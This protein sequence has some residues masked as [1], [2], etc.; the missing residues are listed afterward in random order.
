MI[1]NTAI[2]AVDLT[3]DELAF[4][5]TLYGLEEIGG[6]RVPAD[7]DTSRAAQAGAALMERGFTRVDDS[8]SATMSA[9][10]HT[11]LA[12]LIQGAAGYSVAVGVSHLV[13]NAPERFWCYV[14]PNHELILHTRPQNDIERFELV[15]DSLA[16]KAR[17]NQ[18]LNAHSSEAPGDFTFFVPKQAL[19]EAEQF[20]SQQGL[21]AAQN[22]LNSLGFPSTFANVVLDEHRQII[23]VTL[24]LKESDEGF[25]SQSST[26]MLIRADTGFWLMEEDEINPDQLVVNPVDGG[27][28]ISFLVSQTRPRTD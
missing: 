12:N 24:T 16:L 7:F 3:Q 6:F 15:P 9:A 20:R 27:V 18:L 23:L 8:A 5:M 4:V 21:A 14:T 1:K 11:D 2:Q 28:A 19:S 25:E 26:A 10:L 17:L 22:Y 13:G